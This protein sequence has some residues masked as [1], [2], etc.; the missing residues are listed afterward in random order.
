MFKVFIAYP[1]EPPPP[2][3]PPEEKEWWEKIIDM[4]EEFLGGV[5]LSKIIEAIKN[6]FNSIHQPGEPPEPTPPE[7][8]VHKFSISAQK[9]SNEGYQHNVRAFFAWVT[10]GY[11]LGKMNE[12]DLN[13]FEGSWTL[14][15]KERTTIN[16]VFGTEKYEEGQGMVVPP[17][18]KIGD[19]VCNAASITA[20]VMADAGVQVECDTPDHPPIPGVP[21]E[22]WCTVCIPSPTYGQCQ[23]QDVHMAN[24]GYE[25]VTLHWKVTGDTLSMWVETEKPPTGGGTKVDWFKIGIII[26]V[27]FLII[28]LVSR[29]KPELAGQALVWTLDHRKT[30]KGIL[31]EA[32]KL[33][34]SWFIVVISVAVIFTPQL[35]EIVRLGFIKWIGGDTLI[36]NWQIAA[37]L[38]AILANLLIRARVARKQPKPRKT[39]LVQRPDGKVIEVIPHRRKRRWRW[40]W[41][42]VAVLFI[43]SPLDGDIPV[44]DAVA[45]LVALFLFARG[46]GWKW[47]VILGVI[48]TVAVLLFGGW[49]NAFNPSYVTYTGL[50]GHLGPGGWGSLSE[51]STPEQAVEAV[52][53]Y[54]SEVDAWNG[55]RLTVPVV[56]L[57]E[58][59]EDEATIEAV[60]KACLPVRCIVML[61]ISPQEDVLAIIEKWTWWNNVWFDVDLEHRQGRDITDLELN[62]WSA[63]YFTLRLSRG[64]YL[65]GVFAFYDF[66]SNPKIWP[67]KAVIWRYPNGIVVPIFDGHCQG[68]Q[69]CK[70]VKYNATR[71]FLKNYE[72]AQEFG[73]MEFVTRWGCGSQYG[74]CGFT[75]QEYW[76]EFKP[77]IY[78]AQ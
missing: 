14:E 30:V 60:I 34:W 20:F 62:L 11:D 67:N 31:H 66:R 21:Q 55:S 78:L 32:F 68:E 61:D 50:Y 69:S 5:D 45:L 15:G 9:P 7:T 40:L 6:W 48:I 42:A 25:K 52:Q 22:W 76:Q 4:I 38:L 51:Y 27:V 1:P 16:A 70:E 43:I 10:S 57:V 74:D 63:K 19:G 44:V 72:K 17:G 59:N 23:V 64:L 12:M 35:R 37:L 28:F 41:L 13:N 73:L 65:P 58:R 53:K 3:P 18:Y 56:N 24:L 36:Q 77:L 71:L 54:A 47:L 39:A 8:K 2:G 75:P 49:F 29:R 33:A 46:R 26:G